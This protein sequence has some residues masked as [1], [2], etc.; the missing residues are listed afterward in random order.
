MRALDFLAQ[1]EVVG[2]LRVLFWGFGSRSLVLIDDIL[3]VVKCHNVL[4]QLHIVPLSRS[5]GIK[6][7]HPVE[8]TAEA[9]ILGHISQ[10]PLD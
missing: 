5:L 4:P 10:V 7:N 6:Q 9:R 2:V 3:K 8:V 1:F